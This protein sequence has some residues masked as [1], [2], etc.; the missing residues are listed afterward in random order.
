MSLACRVHWSWVDRTGDTVKQSQRRVTSPTSKMFR[1][2][3]KCSLTAR[4]AGTSFGFFFVSFYSASCLSLGD[5]V[6]RCLGQPVDLL[7]PWPSAAVIPRRRSTVVHFQSVERRVQRTWKGWRTFVWMNCQAVVRRHWLFFFFFLMLMRR[8]G[9]GERGDKIL[10]WRHSNCTHYDVGRRETAWVFPE[11]LGPV[12]QW[13]VQRFRSERLRVWSRRSATFTP[14]AHVRRQSLPVWPPTLNKIPLPFTCLES[15]RTPRDFPR[16]LFLYPLPSAAARTAPNGVKERASFCL[17]FVA[18]TQCRLTECFP[19]ATEGPNPPN[20]T[21]TF[22][23]EFFWQTTS[24]SLPAGLKQFLSIGESLKFN[25]IQ[26][27]KSSE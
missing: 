13:L 19:W 9:L 18:W 1:Q 24:G 22:K 8:R 15:K 4:R 3:L 26:T 7:A 14:S 10:R 27:L 16:R 17:V 2:H 12:V 25:T 20:E 21:L 5:L 23:N 6:Q 11:T